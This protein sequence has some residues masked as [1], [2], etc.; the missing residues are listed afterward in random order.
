M[1]HATNLS[2]DPPRFLGPDQLR[3]I[4]TGAGIDLSRSIVTSCGS[5]VT[6]ALDA[7]VLTRLGCGDVAVYDGSW[8]EWGDR[9]DVPIEVGDQSER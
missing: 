9:D 3:E 7:F 6:A 8:A 5:G 4:Y 1:P 2:G